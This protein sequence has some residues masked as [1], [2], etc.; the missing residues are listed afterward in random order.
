MAR[1]AWA[2]VRDERMFADQVALR[3]DWYLDL[4]SRRDALNAALLARMPGLRELVSAS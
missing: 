3:R 2:Y 1:R 4:W